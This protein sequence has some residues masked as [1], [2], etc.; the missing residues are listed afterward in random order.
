M[1]MSK[2]GRP[3]VETE[4]V[5]ARMCDLKGG[6]IDQSTEKKVM[7]LVG[8]V[9]S[10]DKWRGTI[11]VEDSEYSEE[12]SRKAPKDTDFRTLKAYLHKSGH[13]ILIRRRDLDDYARK[14]PK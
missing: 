7:V 6:I 13:V 14:H 3:L 5:P 11:C 2:E 12:L 9:D 10:N 1:A 4:T 8:R